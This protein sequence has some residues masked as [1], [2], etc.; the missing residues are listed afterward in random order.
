MDI[1]K[2]GLV[3]LQLIKDSNKPKQKKYIKVI[4]LQ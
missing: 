3:T 2:A 4:K 1:F